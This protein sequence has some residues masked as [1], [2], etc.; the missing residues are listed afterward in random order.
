[1]PADRLVGF[2]M[3][4]VALVA[5]AVDKVGTPTQRA[6]RQAAPAVSPTPSPTA[7]Q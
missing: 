5:V 6:A 2:A 4:W 3:V 1:M 7:G